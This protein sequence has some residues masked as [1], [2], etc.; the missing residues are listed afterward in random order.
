MDEG[1]AYTPYAIFRRQNTDVAVEVVGVMI[2][3]WLDGV[4]C[5]WDE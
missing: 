5:L 3:A 4:K 2:R 1:E